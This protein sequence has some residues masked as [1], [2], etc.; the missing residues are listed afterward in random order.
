MLATGEEIEI[1]AFNSEP[2]A[3]MWAEALCREGVPSLVRSKGIGPAEW[4]S[5]AHQPHGLYVLPQE[6]E[7]ARA[8]VPQEYQ[9]WPPPPERPRAAF[10]LRPLIYVVSFALMGLL[11]WLYLSQ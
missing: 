2:L 6:E 10:S 8:L 7:R 5:A 9:V 1:A 3:R 11:L 4:G